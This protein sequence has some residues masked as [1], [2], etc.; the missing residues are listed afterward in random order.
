MRG[1]AD[2]ID[3]ALTQCHVGTIDREDQFSGDRD[4]FALKEAKLGRRQGR[5]IGIRDQV[6]NCESHAG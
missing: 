5:E 3:F 1:A 6:R 4:P 2:K